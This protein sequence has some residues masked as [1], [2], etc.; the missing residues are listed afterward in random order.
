MSSRSLESYS[1][2]NEAFLPKMKIKSIEPAS[3]STS[4]GKILCVQSMRRSRNSHQ[5]VAM[6]KQEPGHSVKVYHISYDD[7]TP[8][9]A[10]CFEVQNTAYF[11]VVTRGEEAKFGVVFLMVCWLFTRR[12]FTQ[13]HADHRKNL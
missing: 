12:F 3:L 6:N 11:P 4:D 2:W 8:C 10:F 7:K 9:M 13:R 5:L 1:V